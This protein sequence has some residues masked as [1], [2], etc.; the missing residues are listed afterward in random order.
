MN[1]HDFFTYD[2]RS[3]SGLLWK[4]GNSKRAVGEFVGHQKEGGYWVT[5]VNYRLVRVHRIIWEMHFG[6]I[7]DGAFIDHINGNPGDNRIQNLRLASSMENSWN[8]KVHK[9][10]ISG[11]KGV[12]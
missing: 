4:I 7:P 12:S 8:S 5:S 6:D 9:D 1:Y 10:S 2:E 11:V 3:P